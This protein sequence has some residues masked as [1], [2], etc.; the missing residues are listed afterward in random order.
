MHL[1]II[2]RERRAA[3]LIDVEAEIA[4]EAVVPT[5]A[6]YVLHVSRIRREFG[7]KHPKFGDRDSGE[8]PNLTNNDCRPF[9]DPNFELRRREAHGEPEEDGADEQHVLQHRAQALR[10]VVIRLSSCC[11][12]RSNSAA[13]NSLLRS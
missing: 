7:A 5:R 8:D 2:Y 11:C 4:E 1:N 3:P 10:F 6:T 12:R 9:K 13:S